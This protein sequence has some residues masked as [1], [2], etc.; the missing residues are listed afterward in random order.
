MLSEIV[1]TATVK[2]IATK[3]I[4]VGAG[5][6]KRKSN[7]ILQALTNDNI[8]E[9]YT[10]NAVN[11]VFVFRTL[12]HGDKNVYLDEVYYP[13]KLDFYDDNPP[14]EVTEETKLPTHSPICIVGIAGQGKTTV[15][16][17]LFLEELVRKESLPF[18]ISLRQVKDYE[19]LTCE[20]LLHKHLT[21]NGIDCDID[22]VCHLCKS[23][24][25]SFYFDGFDEIPFNQRGFALDIIT[26]IYERYR[27][28]VTVTTRPETEI[29]RAPGYDTY[30]VNFLDATD[31]F[32]ILRNTIT[33]YNAHDFIVNLLQ[34]K[35][36]LMESIRTPILLD[37]F[38]ITSTALRED[39]NSI[40]DYYDG[41]FSALLHRH[42]LIKNL[43]RTKKSNLPDRIL[44]QSFALFS[45][46]SL[47]NSKGDFSRL[48]INELFAKSATALKIDKLPEDIADDIIDGTNILVKDGYD[49]YV[50]IHKSIQEYF[51]AKCISTMNDAAKEN[52]YN[53][54]KKM[55]QYELG[56]SFMIM[57]SY[58]DS[59]SFIKFYILEKLHK[60]Q[61]LNDNIITLLSKEDYIRHLESWTLEIDLEDLG[62]SSLSTQRTEHWEQIQY[63]EQISNYISLRRP[64]LSLEAM[65]NDILMENG[66]K[67]ANLVS[68]GTIKT[69]SKNDPRIEDLPNVNST[70]VFIDIASTKR[71]I[72]N[73]DSIFDITY[74]NY[75]ELV[76]IINKYIQENYHDKIESNDILNCMID[77]IKFK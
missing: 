57:V 8:I 1:I 56:T 6:L 50:Y 61:C 22:D 47:M 63:I 60:A 15:M 25:I 65:G 64:I 45:F 31:I 17:K 27:C 3:L 19:S 54:F 20:G 14:I 35:S 28:P 34:T 72:D 68:K 37:I 76:S 70:S 38:I 30:K 21:S 2:S 42:D 75:I 18:F 32:A 39:P 43:T 44:E 48:E 33:D 51:A 66:D 11:R 74:R 24:K 26:T 52:I 29:T 4:D 41:L 55:S 12:I 69:L 7:K 77:N 10:Q 67:I 16:R 40:S 59:F 5:A 9:H 62:C 73:Y 46:F 58:L 13:L 49:N 36:F 53:N 23:K 71:F